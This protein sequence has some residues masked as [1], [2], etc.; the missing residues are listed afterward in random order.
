MPALIA[1]LS[2]EDAQR[3]AALGSGE[4]DRATAAK[5]RE[6][7]KMRETETEAETEDAHG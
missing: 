5:M 7:T 6:M 1:L 2:P 3:L 4:K